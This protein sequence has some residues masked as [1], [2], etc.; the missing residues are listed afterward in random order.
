MFR[1]ICG[2]V[3]SYLAISVSASPLFALERA[4]ELALD[5][6]AESPWVGS[7][8][9]VVQYYNLCTG[10]FWF[11]ESQDGYRSG[12][13]FEACHPGCEVVSATAYFIDH[14]Q[15][16]RGYT[17]LIGL[18]AVDENDCPQEPPL[19]SMA[20]IQQQGWNT[21]Q[22]AGVPTPTRFALMATHANSVYGHEIGFISDH[23]A[24]GPTGPPACGTCFPAD[25]VTH[26]YDWGS[27]NSP[28]CPGERIA[29]AMC[30]AEFV[31]NVQLSCA[32][33]VSESSWSRIRSMFR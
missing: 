16:G 10:W 6:S 1:S 31:L 22:F 2:V 20:Y 3:A 13:V 5:L 19:A 18:Y 4:R 9:C 8:T 14:G 30:P 24:A 11:W 23:P 17:A 28:A 25:R 33:T 12:T 29:D 15:S 32:S 21:F 7:E 27:V 26:S